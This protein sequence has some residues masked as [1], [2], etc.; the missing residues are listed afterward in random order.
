[1]ESAAL[2]KAIIETA[3][4]GIITI[5]ERGKIETINPAA[6]NLFQ[7]T[8]AEVI[9]KNINVLMP[10]PYRENHDGYIARY[11]RTHDPHI[12]GIGREVVG[13]KKDGTMFPFRLAVSE[14]QYLERKVYTGF[15][16][17]LSREKDAED[18]L[19]DYAAKLEELVE[20]RTLSL[21][22]T[23]KALQHAKEEVSI[24]LEKEKELSQLTSRFVSLASHEFRTP[25]SAIQLSAV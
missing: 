23:V 10:S 2:L 17:D 4:D 16:H 6:C 15:I 13:L 9:G 5:D 3:I 24:S 22:E 19:R 18:K 21:Q 11:Q 7:Y 12:I 8:P 14:V 20:E 1:M 25:L